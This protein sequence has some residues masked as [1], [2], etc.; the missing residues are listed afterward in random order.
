MVEAAGDS[1]PPVAGGTAAEAVGLVVAEKCLGG[2]VDREL[3]A[4]DP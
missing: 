3:P 2:R 4:E 1:G